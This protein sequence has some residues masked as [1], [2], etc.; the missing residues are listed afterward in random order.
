MNNVINLNEKRKQKKLTANNS[1]GTITAGLSGNYT[2]A[3]NIK[4]INALLEKLGYKYG[5]KPNIQKDLDK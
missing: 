2:V 4:R 1:T 5:V 3:E